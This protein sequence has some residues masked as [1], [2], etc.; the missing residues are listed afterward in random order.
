MAN[1]LMF[2]IW[3]YIWLPASDVHSQFRGSRG[4][5]SLRH[6]DPRFESSRRTYVWPPFCEVPSDGRGLAMAW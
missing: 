2:E 4:L 5:M 3:N 1:E 6:W